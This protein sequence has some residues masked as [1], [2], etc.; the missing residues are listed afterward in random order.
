MK[1]ANYGGIQHHISIS[2]NFV[3]N[4]GTREVAVKVLEKVTTETRNMLSRKHIES[5][6]FFKLP[7]IQEEKVP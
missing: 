1:K 4:I 7:I 6:L 5:L 3:S 2:T